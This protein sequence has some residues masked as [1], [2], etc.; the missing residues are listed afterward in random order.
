MS[1]LPLEMIDA[2]AAALKKGLSPVSLARLVALAAAGGDRRFHLQNDFSDW[3]TAMHTF[4][5]AH[6]V[7][8]SLRRSPPRS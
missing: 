2:M 8:E 3:I 1:D 5:H 6:A 7:H 4:I